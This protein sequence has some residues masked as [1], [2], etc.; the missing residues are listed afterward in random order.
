MRSR[1]ASV[2]CYFALPAWILGSPDGMTLEH[3]GR[4]RA[5]RVITLASFLIFGLLLIVALGVAYHGERLAIGPTIV[6]LVVLAPLGLWPT[7]VWVES[8][9]AASRGTVPRNRV[10]AALAAS[11]ALPV[12]RRAAWLVLVV[13]VAGI[14]AAV[15]DARRIVRED[16]RA[17][18]ACYMLYDD[19]DFLG[20]RWPSWIFELG[21]WRVARAAEARW[22]PGS[23]VVAP[24]TPSNLRQALEHGRFLFLATHGSGGQVRLDDW[25]FGPEAVGSHGEDLKLVYITACE[26]GLKRDDWRHSLE[27]AQVFTFPRLS[28]VNEHVYWLWVRGPRCVAA[29][30]ER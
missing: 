16:C 26:A 1:L 23:V 14:A 7:V 22:G 9:H 18:A 29:L 21:F 12:L 25:T 19:H 20:H 10:V 4:A 11:Q 27:G 13:G 30:A 28:L 8:I 15:Q 17:P 6:A 5:L 24:L 3:E 2:A